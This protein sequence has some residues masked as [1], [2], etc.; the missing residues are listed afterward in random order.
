MSKQDLIQHSRRWD[1]TGLILAGLCLV[2]CL[3]IPFIV[4]LMPSARIFLESPWLE[5]SILLSG[6]AVGSISFYASF[7]KHRQKGPILLGL[8]GVILLVVSLFQGDSHHAHH[9]ISLAA[10]DPWVL[11]GG[12]FLIAGHFGN[13]QACHCFCPSQC[14]H[15]EPSN[16]NAS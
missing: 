4:V 3:S 7:R 16:H 9:Q 1:R 5:S 15:V 8:L 13:I 14:T 10:L 12:L 2:H 11:I 6:I